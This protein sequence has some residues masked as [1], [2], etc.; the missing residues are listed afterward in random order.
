MYQRILVPLDGSEPAE[1]ALLHA[2]EVAKR[3]GAELILFQAITPLTQLL[4]Q[5]APTSL[6]VATVGSQLADE[7]YEA[8]SATARQYMERTGSTLGGQDVRVRVAVMDG[9]PGDAILAQARQHAVDLIVM[10]T[11]GRGGLGRL[12]FGSVADDVI[13]NSS[14]PVLL[15]RPRRQ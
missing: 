7:A 8:S 14:I 4:A 1:T 9:A 13:R 11:H 10:S 2:V 6:E 15:V 3:F 5:A 12:V